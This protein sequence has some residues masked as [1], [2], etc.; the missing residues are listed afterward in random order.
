MGDDDS[1]H[2]SKHKRSHESGVRDR[3]KS[4][5]RHKS[6][7]GESG[8]RRNEKGT[9]STR[10]VDDD[11]NDDDMWVESNIDM[12]GERVRTTSAYYGGPCLCN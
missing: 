9:E 12:D 3:H 5:K 4:S 1:K 8:K 6:H 7:K 2:S 11:A 10:V